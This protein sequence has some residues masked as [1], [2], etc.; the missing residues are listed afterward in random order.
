MRNNKSKSRSNSSKRGRRYS[1]RSES[2]E[3]ER[4]TSPSRAQRK[5]ATELVRRQSSSSGQSD[6]SSPKRPSSRRRPRSRSVSDVKSLRRNGRSRSESGDSY[7]RRNS[8]PN[9]NRRRSSSSESE[10]RNGRGKELIRKRPN[11]ADNGRSKRERQ[12]NGSNKYEELVKRESSKERVETSSVESSAAVHGGGRQAKLQAL[13]GM[14]LV[15]DNEKHALS[16]EY[17]DEIWEAVCRVSREKVDKNLD[18]QLPPVN[19]S[20]HEE[21]VQKS[22][23]VASKQSRFSD[24]P[25][26]NRESVGFSDGERTKLQEGVSKCEKQMDSLTEELEEVEHVSFLSISIK[27]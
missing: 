12:S 1:D 20:L 6:R 16:N 9:R 21:V 18:S 3:A 27:L 13:I 19:S 2:S 17:I 14:G 10:Q 22:D 8:K 23:H 24:G 4:E 7:D 26:G 25:A 5:R 15:K 11:G